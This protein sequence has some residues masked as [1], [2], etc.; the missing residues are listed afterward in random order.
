MKPIRNESGFIPLEVFLI[1]AAALV[2]LLA[3]VGLWSHYETVKNFEKYFGFNPHDPVYEGRRSFAEPLVVTKLNELD[4]KAKTAAEAVNAIY[5]EPASNTAESL[6]DKLIRFQ[7]E[8]R[9]A[10]Q[11][12]SD[13]YNACRAA[14]FENYVKKCDATK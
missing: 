2:G 1:V 6:K 13:W 10:K 11:A 8:E 4:N 5:Q 12:Y 14:K 7:N 3:V 9:K